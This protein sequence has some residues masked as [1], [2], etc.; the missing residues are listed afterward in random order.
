MEASTPSNLCMDARRLPGALI[1]DVPRRVSIGNSP[2]LNQTRPAVPQPASDRPSGNQ[3]PPGGRPAPPANTPPPRRQQNSPPPQRTPPPSASRDQQE[4]QGPPQDRRTPP[5]SNSQQVLLDFISGEQNRRGPDRDPPPRSSGINRPNGGRDRDIPRDKSARQTQDVIRAVMRFLSSIEPEL[6]NSDTSIGIMESIYGDMKTYQSML[7]KESYNGDVN[8]MCNYRGVSDSLP[9]HLRNTMGLLFDNMEKAKHEAKDKKNATKLLQ[10]TLRKNIKPPDLPKLQGQATYLR[11]YDAIVRFMEY[12][13][14]TRDNDNAIWQAIVN[15]LSPAVKGFISMDNVSIKHVMTTYNNMFK[16]NVVEAMMEAHIQPLHKNGQKPTTPEASYKNIC[17]VLE[18]VYLIRSYSNLNQVSSGSLRLMEAV[19]FTEFTHNSYMRELLTYQAE[20]NGEI[21]GGPD[22]TAGLNVTTGQL[23]FGSSRAANSLNMG[24]S[25][26]DDPEDGNEFV[27]LDNLAGP[28]TTLTTRDRLTFFILFAERQKKLLAS[29]MV[30]NNPL[31]MSKDPNKNHGQN[32]M[33]IHETEGTAYWNTATTDKKPSTRA[34]KPKRLLAKLPC[35]VLSLGCNNH[36][37]E[38]GS[39]HFC[40]N[41]NEQNQTKRRAILE[42]D[43]LCKFCLCSAHK[44]GVECAY[45][46]IKCKNCNTQGDHHR[47]SGLCP[48]E[49]KQLPGQQIMIHDGKQTSENDSADSEDEDTV[50]SE[51]FLEELEGESPDCNYHIFESNPIN[52]HVEDDPESFKASLIRPNPYKHGE[53]DVPDDLIKKIQVSVADL[54]K[55]I[56]RA[57]ATGLTETQ[58]AQ[59]KQLEGIQMLTTAAE[60]EDEDDAVETL[61]MMT[62]EPDLPALSIAEQMKKTNVTVPMVMD[63]ASSRYPGAIY[64]HD[65]PLE[66][67]RHLKI[68]PSSTGASERI[69]KHL[70]HVST[71]LFRTYTNSLMQQVPV[72]LRI[73]DD[74]AFP[75]NKCDLKDSKIIQLEDNQRYL[76]VDALLDTGTHNNLL[77]ALSNFPF[78]PGCSMMTASPDLLKCLSCPKLESAK[79]SVN[80][81]NGRMSVDLC[82]HSNPNLALFFPGLVKTNDYLYELILRTKTGEDLKICAN[83]FPSGKNLRKGTPYTTLMQRVIKEE[84]GM[85]P[86]MADKFYMPSQAKTPHLLLGISNSLVQPRNVNPLPLGLKPNLFCPDLTIFSL[87][88]M[89]GFEYGVR[90][91]LGIRTA[92]YSKTSNAPWFWVQPHN[93]EQGELLPWQTISPTLLADIQDECNQGNAQLHLHMSSRPEEEIPGRFNSGLDDLLAPARQSVRDMGD[94]T[95]LSDEAC[96]FL[97]QH[98]EQDQHMTLAEVKSFERFICGETSFSHLLPVCKEHMKEYEE[99]LKTCRQCLISSDPDSE[100]KRKLA[101]EIEKNLHVVPDTAFNEG[102]PPSEHRFT[103]VQD[104][105]TTLPHQQLGHLSHN[106]FLQ[107]KKAAEKLVR[108][109]HG[110]PTMAVLDA[111]NRKYLEA[112]KLRIVMPEVIDSIARGETPAQFYCRGIVFKP[113]SGKSPLKIRPPILNMSFFSAS[114]PA[115]L[116]VDTSRKIHGLPVNLSSNSQSPEGYTPVL[117]DAGLHLYP[118]QPVKLMISFISVCRFFWEKLFVACDISKACKKHCLNTI[119]SHTHTLSLADHSIRLSE[120]DFLLFCSIWYNNVTVDGAKLLYL[121]YNVMS[122]FGKSPLSIRPP[123]LNMSFFFPSGMGSAHL[124]LWSGVRLASTQCELNESQKQ[125]LRNLFVDNIGVTGRELKDIFPVLLD[126]V[127]T[128]ARFGLNIDKFYCPKS[129]NLSEHLDTEYEMP[130][131]VI[132]L[133]LVWL[134]GT[135]EILPRIRL[136]WFGSSRGQPGGPGL[137]ATDVYQQAVTRRTYARLMAQCYDTLGRFIGIIVAAA[138]LKCKKLC[139]KTPNTHLDADVAKVDPELAREIQTFWHA[140]K[141]LQT[142]IKPFPRSVLRPGDTIEY[143]VVSHDASPLMVASVAHVISKDNNNRLQSHVLGSKSALNSA[144]TP[145]NEKLSCLQAADVLLGVVKSVDLE[146][147]ENRTAYIIGDSTIASYLFSGEMYQG[148]GLSRSI[149]SKIMAVLSVCHQLMPDI[150]VHFAWV[151]GTHLSCADWLTKECEPNTLISKVNST[152]WRHGDPLL[153]QPSLLERFVYFKYEKGTGSYMAL[154]EHLRKLNTF[155]GCVLLTVALEADQPA[156]DE[157]YTDTDPPNILY[158]FHPATPEAV[159]IFLTHAASEPNI[160]IIETTVTEDL[161]SVRHSRAKA[162]AVNTDFTPVEMSDYLITRS[163]KDTCGVSSLAFA[164]ALEPTY[165]ASSSATVGKFNKRTKTWDTQLPPA[166]PSKKAGYS[167]FHRDPAT[168]RIRQH[169]FLKVRYGKSFLRSLKIS[170]PSTTV[171]NCFRLSADCYTLPALLDHCTVPDQLPPPLP[172][173]DYL[174]ILR[175]MTKLHSIVNV[176]TIVILAAN[177]RVRRTWS[178]EDT[179]VAAWVWLLR[180]DQKHFP[181][182]RA[183]DVREDIDVIYNPYAVEDEKTKQYMASLN[184]PQ[185]ASD[186]PLLVKLISS[187]HV[188]STTR[189]REPGQPGEGEEYL[190]EVH[191]SLNRTLSILQTGFFSTTACNLKAVASAVLKDCAGCLRTRPLYYQCRVG[192]RYAGRLLGTKGAWTRTSFDEI[193][194]IQCATRPGGRSNAQTLKIWIYCFACLDTKAICFIPSARI[195]ASGLGQALK[196]FSFK[197]GATPAELYSDRFATHTEK[198]LRGI[199]QTKLTVFPPHAKWRNF[200]E[201][202]MKEVKKYLRSLAMKQTGEPLTLGSLTTLDVMYVFDLIAYAMNTTPVTST[203]P[204]TPAMIVW[205]GVLGR[206]GQHF[207]EE[208]YQNPGPSQSSRT[209]DKL[210][211]QYKELILQER[212]KAILT[213]EDQH[214][215]HPD[216]VHPTKKGTKSNLLP[217]KNDVA[218]LDNGDGKGLRFARVVSVNDNKTSAE[219]LTGGKLKTVAVRNLR[220]LSIFRGEDI[221]DTTSVSAKH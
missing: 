76:I 3:N 96:M 111:Q 184:K 151:P 30:D 144:T 78:I 160:D 211:A 171:V 141:D 155:E 91:T 212:Q 82:L 135:D 162:R 219:V 169:S 86:E 200:V 59:K 159:T 187:I 80:T 57:Q 61:M 206:M 77:P 17:R 35:P 40:D 132:M 205:P 39:A 101:A 97:V 114:T 31:Q 74:N 153:L 28:E 53:P 189:D 32:H 202:R 63:A 163:G 99:V 139:A 104:L 199:G 98:V 43:N 140:L 120:K 127:K 106:N 108:R 2:R 197:T 126:I 154:P 52:F 33:V 164:P 4:G 92:G 174:Q 18:N 34:R 183:G 15:S 193:G 207:E 64:H 209:A 119:L 8:V 165:L 190:G 138:K 216:R 148:D 150:S 158:Y 25:I 49:P 24:K 9:R 177:S 55:S 142:S 115:R 172:K 214:R 66:S 110:T 181:P 213:I 166:S 72:A 51:C 81:G 198:G 1:T 208:L 16:V 93:I 188:L 14:K 218:L 12:N 168:L 85:G 88:V 133:G 46:N 60:Q 146:W 5:P 134:L 113:D 203:S 48:S 67:V 95:A 161:F 29:V 179:V 221:A 102:K 121:V 201:I 7:T 54:E 56:L 118:S 129:Y 192:P 196:W 41:F 6:D 38:A 215:A 50:D 143:V 42:Q 191:C 147:T 128:L 123:I 217:E 89:Y 62:T 109:H 131:S 68:G 204:L 149:F 180:S 69:F 176:L 125:L 175:K 10:E 13:G 23:L 44:D 75:D 47:K 112:D 116:I 130:D 156:F 210:L 194:P 182:Q 167:T 220:I 27:S 20:R 36:L 71:K 186:S 84:Y 19:S 26:L 87:N 137:E 173:L 170:Q 73:T 21:P 152:T 79:M 195:D 103:L 117:S 83:I 107:A 105:V 124:S 94:S 157:V 45:K 22:T 136:S 122:D 58:I 185:L 145:R 178:P 11:W 100:R 37:V 70:Y 90:G 65:R